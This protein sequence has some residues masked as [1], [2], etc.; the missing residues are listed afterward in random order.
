MAENCLKFLSTLRGPCTELSTAK[1]KDIPNLLPKL[2]NIIRV[3]WM[4]SE[5]YNTREKLTN[6]LRKV[7]DNILHCKMCI[8][9]TIF[10][11]FRLVMR[12]LSDATA[13]F[14]WMTFLLAMWSGVR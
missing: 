5:H 11:S 6:L 4:N 7:K 2:L 12:L 9:V 10:F 3:I 14:H 8:Y 13:V 1:P